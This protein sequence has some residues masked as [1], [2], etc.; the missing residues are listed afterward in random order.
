[1][2]T[3]RFGTTAGQRPKRA[4]GPASR[5][6][7]RARSSIA[8]STS[9]SFHR[10][11]AADGPWWFEY[12]HFQ[13][14]KHFAERNGYKFGYAARLFAAILYEWSEVNAVVRAEVTADSLL[15]WKGKGKQVLASGSDSRDVAAPH[16]SVTSMA[17]TTRH[18]TPMQG[19]LEVYQ[20][21]IPGLGNPHRQFGNFM[22]LLGTR[23]DS[24][25]DEPGSR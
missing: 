14:I 5:K 21:F 10:R 4:S 3:A 17:R 8:S 24:R 16:G 25:P 20:M 11:I 18:M 9:A 13:T 23:A 15:V 7:A 12:E 1:M 6:S 22:R 2:P 19:N